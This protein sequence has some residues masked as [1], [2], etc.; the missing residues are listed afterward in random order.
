MNAAL[1]ILFVFVGVP[2]IARAIDRAMQDRA[3]KDK[4]LRNLRREQAL[5]QERER[6]DVKQTS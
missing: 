2:L 5:R 3:N 1:V 6:Q 4:E